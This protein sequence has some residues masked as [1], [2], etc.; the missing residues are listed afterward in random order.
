MVAFSIRKAE[1][2]KRCKMMIGLLLGACVIS[3]GAENQNDD[4]TSEYLYARAK[5]FVLPKTSQSWSE[6]IGREFDFSAPDRGNFTFFNNAK[7]LSFSQADQ[8]L[9]F[10]MSGEN[11][12]LGWGNHNNQQ[13]ESKRFQIWPSIHVRILARQKDCAKSVWKTKPYL[14]GI[15]QIFSSD[16][17]RRKDHNIVEDAILTGNDWQWLDFYLISQDRTKNIDAFSID[18]QAKAGTEIEIK[19]FVVA[20]DYYQGRFRKEFSI[21]AGGIWRAVADVGLNTIL[22]INGRKIET[23]TL[24]RPRPYPHFDYYWD[25]Y[26]TEKIN[27]APYLKPGQQNCIG[28]EGLSGNNNAPNLYF[29]GTVVMEDGTIIN[30]DSDETW[31]WKARP[32]NLQWT[33]TGFDDAGW[34]R[35][36]AGKAGVQAVKWWKGEFRRKTD[37]PVYNGYLVLENPAETR[38]IFYDDK[39]FDLIVKAP[40]GLKDKSPYVE[41]SLER[42]SNGKTETIGAGTIK[43][44]VAD[45][46]SLA[47]D[48]KA[49]PLKTGI[50]LLKLKMFS[51][52]G[53][54][55]ENRMPEPLAV[56]GKIKMREVSGDFY[57]Q[58]MELELEHHL[59]FTDPK[60]P[61]LSAETDGSYVRTFSYYKELEKPA[62]PPLLAENQGLKYRLTRPALGA[63]FSYIVKEFKHPGEFYLGVLEYPDD[64][65]RGLA[66]SVVSELMVEKG[67]RRALAQKLGLGL[68]LG[69]KFPL[70]N[71]MQQMKFVF[72]PDNGVHAFNIMSLMKNS[73][74]AAANLKLYYIGNG[75]PALKVPAESQRQIGYL[76]ESWPTDG[77]NWGNWYI[78]FRRL[79]DPISENGGKCNKEGDPALEMC[80]QQEKWLDAAEHYVQYLRFTG[81]N[82]HAMEMYMYNETS[83]PFDDQGDAV[84]PSLRH[85]MREIVSR[86][87]NANNI[88][89]VGSVEYCGSL[90]L[91]KAHEEQNDFT[92]LYRFDKKGVSLK[93]EVYRG[94]NWNH[95]E[96][97]NHMLKV[98][99][100]TTAQFKNLPNFKGLNWMADWEGEFLPGW[101]DRRSQ[102]NLEDPL[103]VGYD[104]WT[105][106]VFQEDTGIKLPDFSQDNPDRFSLRYQLLTSPELKPQWEAWRCERL[107]KCFQSIRAEIKNQRNDLILTITPFIG[108]PQLVEQAKSG[109]SFQEYFRSCGYDVNKLKNISDLAMV[110]NLSATESYADY[111]KMIPGYVLP[112]K[113]YSYKWNINTLEE[114]YDAYQGENLRAILVMHHWLEMECYSQRLPSETP[115]GGFWP[116]AYQET[117]EAHKPARYA[118]EVYTQGMIGADP[119][120]L[121]FGFSDGGYLFGDEQYLRN[122]SKVYRRL[123]KAKFARY[124]N[125]GFKTNLAI[126]ELRQ[127]GKLYFYVANPGFWDIAGSITLSGAGK[128]VDIADEKTVS[129]SGGTVVPVKIGPFGI[130]GFIADSDKAQITSWK[131]D[132]IAESDIAYMQGINKQVEGFLK[133]NRIRA[134]LLPSEAIFMDASVADIE[135]ALTNGEYAA[136]WAAITSAR[137]WNN[138]EEYLAAQSEELRNI[139]EENIGN[140]KVDQSKRCLEAIHVDAPPVIDGELNDPAWKQA[141]SQ[142]GFMQADGTPAKAGTSVMAVYDKDNVYFA[143]ICKDNFPLDIKG[144]QN[145]AEIGFHESGDIVN[146]MLQPDLKENLYYQLGFNF[147]GAKFDQQVVRGGR[148]YAFNPGW[149]IGIVRTKAGWTAETKIPAK[150]LGGAAAAGNRWGADF[151]RI[152][153]DNLVPPSMWNFMPSGNWHNPAEF[154]A[155]L[156]K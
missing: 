123:P 38:L 109:L 3:F 68:L 41:W 115:W 36:G 73:S 29:R 66:L 47:Y 155:L 31:K 76:T 108:A 134:A 59:D 127:D 21:P 93:Y 89:F 24:I 125:T 135:K 49:S 85:D 84:T 4:F 144:S 45:T 153:R 9:K 62:T 95:P 90:A 18:I 80:A 61:Y 57:E 52:D 32:E 67:T 138:W 149:T 12:T 6:F 117:I 11:A 28:L 79:V 114:I 100:K 145:A 82:F 139:T 132:K 42:Y 137:F 102:Y 105:V 7:D 78:A 113:K 35:V 96:I 81:Q 107:A 106:K 120:L 63:E 54:L 51:Q 56:V 71:K 40:A 86:L 50:Y 44:F 72:R 116:R 10:V 39:P 5:N 150:D 34:D 110:Q 94:L 53:Q 23:D 25:N 142:S 14:A 119:N 55:I 156:F 13:A 27:L 101:R 26:C 154:G 128:V 43:A 46:N 91:Q 97:M 148:D 122:F 118:G 143:F 99:R 15:Y 88:S 147:G 33:E 130:I 103:G 136:A 112:Y 133:D 74:A 65:K 30:L 64:A 75:L 140:T 83:N 58:G 121:M 48:L 19:K 151:Y 37:R 77:E 69:G 87:F 60:S 131:T 17:Q 8:A 92:S 98:A 20:R 1:N 129:S 141:I 152:F 104:D 124:N 111:I 2:M 126:R 146:L 22:Y 70:S 16:A